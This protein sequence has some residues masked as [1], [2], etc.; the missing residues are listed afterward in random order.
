MDMRY[1]SIKFS[2][3]IMSLIIQ[4]YKNAC[5]HPNHPALWVDNIFYS[6][7]EL[8]DRANQLSELMLQISSKPTICA[9]LSDRNIATYQ[10]ILASLMSNHAYLPL[11]PD[12]PAPRNIDMIKI[13]KPK[14]LAIDTNHQENVK[15]ILTT[16]NSLDVI[17]F[18]DALLKLLVSKFPKHRYHLWQ[19]QPGCHQKAL[20]HSPKINSNSYC[21][22]LFT[23]GTTGIPKGILITNNNLSAYLTSISSIYQPSF[24]DRFSHHIELTFDLAAHEMFVCWYA[25]GTL[26]VAPNHYLLGIAQ[27]IQKHQITY[28]ISVP[29]TITLL[30]QLG[31]LKANTLPT[32]KHS[33]FCGEPLFQ[34]Q[35]KTWQIA[36]P[37]SSIINLYG[38][39]EA[40][41]A[42]THF[43]WSLNQSD[44]QPA[45]V[46]IGKPLPNQTCVLSPK[47]SE[48]CL[49]GTQVST[50]YLN[51]QKTTKRKFKTSRHNQTTRVW[52]RSGDLA[53]WDNRFG[54][55]YLGRIDDQ[56]QIRGQRIEKLE[57]ENQWRKI[58]NCDVLAI[59]PIKNTAGFI[60]N[61]LLFICQDLDY[62]TLL[63]KARLT[64]PE[65]MIPKRIIKLDFLP[66]N[67]SGKIDYQQLDQIATAKK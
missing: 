47:T 50:G 29:S 10:T 19:P 67:S 25:G 21:Y 8:F 23:S 61:I 44:Q 34:S 1:G 46:P 7:R 65:I 38:P 62:D 60:E 51:D 28:W 53:T 27:F 48:L 49:S 54:Y 42:F 4:F 9:I 26:Y 33:F 35:A 6:Y 58:T 12:L 43:S 56:W 17:I 3:E 32:L 11:L 40:T 16:I 55:L 22:L 24:Q 15:T 37:N 30:Q 41:I 5:K 45:I 20:T 13:A 14:I 66:T 2:R 59:S 64:L 18:K 52:Y 31:C 63:K 39:T 36:A 57:I